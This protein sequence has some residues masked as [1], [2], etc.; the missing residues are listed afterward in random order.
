[1]AFPG[2]QILSFD[3][4]TIREIE[5]EDTS[6]SQIYSRFLGDRENFLRQLFAELDFENQRAE[7]D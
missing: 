3:G 1:L 4:G 5:Y 6:S 2:A 7:A